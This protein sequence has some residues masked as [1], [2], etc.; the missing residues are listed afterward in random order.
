MAS[1][2][3]DLGLVVD[4]VLG[5]VGIAHQAAGERIA[6]RVG[7]EQIAALLK[8]RN[9]MGR[10]FGVEQALAESERLVRGGR[11]APLF[12]AA[13]TENIEETP[14]DPFAPVIDAT[15]R[16]LR[17]LAQGGAGTPTGVAARAAIAE[18]GSPRAAR[19]ALRYRAAPSPVTVAVPVVGLNMP[20]LEGS[21]ADPRGKR[22]PQFAVP[23]RG[24]Y[25]LFNPR[26]RLT[27]A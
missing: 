21:S 16:Q 17:R 14:T 2:G 11:L 8:I 15:R 3:G 7:K 18:F 25:A 12:E 20:L 22:R 6:K 1:E 4:L 19:Q 23:P 24:V 9:E 5:P 26:R 13:G 27:Y 10:E